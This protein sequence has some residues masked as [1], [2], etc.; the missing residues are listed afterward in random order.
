MHWAGHV[1]VW[2]TEQ[3]CQQFQRYAAETE[4]QALA[5]EILRHVKTAKKTEPGKRLAHSR[6]LKKLDH[7]FKSNDVK[8]VIELLVSSGD[9]TMEQDP[10]GANGRA[11]IFY[12]A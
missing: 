10:K 7:R 11:P 8:G 6:L 3:M 4:T 5:K 2:A 1:A 12:R 9:M